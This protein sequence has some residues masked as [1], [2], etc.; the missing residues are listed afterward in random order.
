MEW[1]EYIQ[2]AEKTLSIQFNIDQQKEQKVLH[3]VIGM[4]TEI[5]ELMENYDV[6]TG[7]LTNLNVNKQ[8]NLSEELADSM[9]YLSILFRE[10]NIANS[11]VEYTMKDNSPFGELLEITKVNLKMLDLLKKK[12]YYNKE[13]NTDLMIECTNIIMYRMYK[14]CSYYN[15]DVSTILDKNIA[16]LKARYGEKF[17]SEKAINRDLNIEKNI[18]EK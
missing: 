17:S 4:L 1:N 5:E 10:Y 9:W 18:L 14:F 15:I 2:L 7:K 3:A 12:I 13:I 8:G 11:K 6:N 16:K